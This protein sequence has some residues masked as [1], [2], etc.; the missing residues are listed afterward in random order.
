[1]QT[2]IKFLGSVRSGS[3][4]LSNRKTEAVKRFPEPTDVRQL[5]RYVRLTN[6]FRKFIRDYTSI[7]GP[8]TNLLKAN[9]EFRFGEVERNAFMQ[10]KTLLSE[11]PVLNLYRVGAKPSYIQT[12][13]NGTREQY[14]CSRILKI[15]KCTRCTTQAARSP[16]PKKNILVTN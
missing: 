14:C 13:R 8:L 15:N 10:L 7:A 4:R 6:Y 5:Q 2:E 12:H 11:K 1:M 16:P 3:I 9:I